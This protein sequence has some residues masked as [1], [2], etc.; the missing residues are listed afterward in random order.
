MADDMSFLQWVFG[1]AATAGAMIAAFLNTRINTVND[2]VKDNTLDTANLRTYIS[3]NYAS[4]TEIQHSLANLHGRIDAV[5]STMQTGFE[6]TRRDIK[7]ML[8]GKI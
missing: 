7:D 3:E 5:N 1:G 8:R 2:R 4:K 6:E